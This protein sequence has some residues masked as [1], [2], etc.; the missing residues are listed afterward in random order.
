MAI[1]RACIDRFRSNYSTEFQHVTANTFVQ[2]QRVKGQGHS[3]C[4]RQRRLT[5]KSVRICCLFNV[6]KEN[7]IFSNKKYPENADNMPDRLA[8][9]R[10]GLRDAIPSQLHAF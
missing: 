10:G 1:T 8:R 9:S 6:V 3:V 5:A 2:G 7:A 4:N